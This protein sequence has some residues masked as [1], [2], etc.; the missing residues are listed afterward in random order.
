M[1]TNEV[2]DAL[3]PNCPIRNILSRIGDI[4]SYFFII[5]AAG[6]I[7]KFV[8]LA[9]IPPTIAGMGMNEAGYSARTLATYNELWEWHLKPFVADFAFLGICPGFALGVIG[10]QQRNKVGCLRFGQLG[11]H[12]RYPA[13]KG[14]YFLLDVP[15]NG[16]GG[17]DPAI[18][19]AFLGAY[20]FLL[21]CPDGC[22]LVNG[23]K[24]L[25]ALTL[26]A[27]VVDTNVKPLFRKLGVEIGRA[28]V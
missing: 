9:Y 14:R 11:F 13:D 15:N 18:E 22:T 5:I 12:I 19:L 26:I 23:G 2:K 6:H 20:A 10:V 25:Y 24:K 8:T 28:H 21:H 1:N 27:S 3:F 4:S 7:W 16:I 17:S